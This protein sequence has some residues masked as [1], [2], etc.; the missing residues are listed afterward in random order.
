M[1]HFPRFLTLIPVFFIFSCSVNQDQESVRKVFSRFVAAVQKA[2]NSALAESAPFLS[3]LDQSTKETA[4]ET[5]RKLFQNNPRF[6]VKLIN[7][8][9]AQVILSDKNGTLFPFKKGADGLWTISEYLETKQTID[10]IP[11]K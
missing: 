4:L 11:R 1:R 3:G 6:S 2:D 10:F 9:N 5:L 7:A 8:Q